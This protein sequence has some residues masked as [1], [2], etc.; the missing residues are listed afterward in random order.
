MDAFK[1][2]IDNILS[3]LKQKQCI[4]VPFFQRSYVWGETEKSLENCTIL[5]DDIIKSI[6][7]NEDYFIGTIITK[8]ENENSE[9]ITLIDGQQRITTILLILKALSCIICGETL[10]TSVYK[11]TH[12]DNLDDSNNNDNFGLKHNSRQ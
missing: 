8:Q 9:I 6:E 7:N 3:K 4:Q 11:L 10:P 5:I 1:N 2:S 12:K